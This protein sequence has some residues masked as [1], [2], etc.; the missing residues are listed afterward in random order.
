VPTSDS[1]T[2]LHTATYTTLS[3]LTQIPPST[4]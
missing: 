2:A 3:Y 1:S 4:S